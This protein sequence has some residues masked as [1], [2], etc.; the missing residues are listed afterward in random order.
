MKLV[1][2]NTNVKAQSGTSKSFCLTRTQHQQPKSCFA[3]QTL[4]PQTSLAQTSVSTNAN[5][6]KSKTTRGSKSHSFSLIT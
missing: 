3:L 2:K 4:I 5:Q 1:I 6:T